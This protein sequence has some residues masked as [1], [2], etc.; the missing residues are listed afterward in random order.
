[1]ENIVFLMRFA[2]CYCAILFAAAAL[3]NGY[4]EDRLLDSAPRS[5]PT[6]R[7][8]RWTST[9][10]LPHNKV[11]C[12]LQ[13][14]DGYLWV[15]TEA[16]LARFDGVR[17]MVV[18]SG[19]ESQR[20]LP[21]VSALAED[22]DTNLWIASNAG[23][24]R[25]D[26]QTIVHY[27]PAHGLPHHK[28][29]KLVA[30]LNG[31][32]WMETDSNMARIQE[33]RIIHFSS[34]QGLAGM[35][36]R[37]VLETQDGT[38]WLGDGRWRQQFDQQSNH[39]MPLAWQGISNDTSV[40][41]LSI[42]RNG[43]LLV[44]TDAGLYRGMAGRWQHYHQASGLTD[45][46]IH[47]IM[48]DS[49]G[50]VWVATRDAGVY[51]LEGGR[52][53][54]VHLGLSEGEFIVDAMIEDREG[55]LWFAT[56][57]G[58]IRLQQ[59]SIRTYTTVDGLVDDYVHCVH[60][61]PDGAIWV[62][63]SRGISWSHGGT[64]AN[65]RRFAPRTEM[66]VRSI[67]ADR[68]TNIWVS[69]YGL[70]TFQNGTLDE[71]TTAL[72]LRSQHIQSLYEDRMGGIWIG[73]GAG[74]VHWRDHRARAFTTFDGLGGNGADV[75][76]EDH[77]GDVWIGNAFGLHRVSGGKLTRFTQSDGLV[78]D[79]VRA[80]HKDAEHSLWIGTANGL[81]R[82]TAGKFFSFG[83]Q[84]GMPE[85]FINQILEDQF[86]AFWI[87]GMAG[88][89]RVPRSSLNAVAEGRSTCARFV[90][91][92]EAD[93]MLTS[94]TTGGVQPAGCRTRD[95]HLWFATTKGV[96]EI[97]PI[98]VRIN[99]NQPPIVIEQFEADDRSIFGG[100][101]E[102][103]NPSVET[104]SRIALS[105]AS[106]SAGKFPLG[107]STRKINLSASRA[108]SIAIHFTANSFVDSE[109][110]RFKYRLHGYDKIWR[111]PYRGER[112]ARYTN[113][114]PGDY[115]FQVIGCNS[116]GY[117]N[118]TG[119]AITFSLA[120]RFTQ[121]A[122]FRFSV[123]FLGGTV[124]LGL[125]AWRLRWQRRA[126]HAEHLAAVEGQRARIARDL[127][128]D[129][130]ATLTGIALELEAVH[131]HGKAKEAQLG[132]LAAEARA[133][134]LDVREMA[135]T[136]NPRC[137]NLG[138]LST[139]LA[140]LAERFCL[141]ADLDCKLDI[142]S[143]ND[144]RAVAARSRH[145]L[146]IVTKEL[147]AN[148]AKHAEAKTVQLKL[149]VVSEELSLTVQDDGRGFDAARTQTGSGLMNLRERLEQAGGVFE[150]HSR[151]GAGCTAVARFP[152]HDVEP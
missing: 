56:R 79:N 11:K 31:E 115:Q 127:H 111:T 69:S 86:G 128:D 13:T 83:K 144:R 119:A 54:P 62:G 117:W 52:F 73:T 105:P 20:P 141:A 90:S 140:E 122:W 100:P 103:M 85:L 8:T 36:P 88:I 26:G 33:G 142:P 39:F 46:F 29:W 25:L 148:I 82:L 104:N 68:N 32:L 59:L 15:G 91:F 41:S 145:E 2:Q 76:L 87:S 80:L 38:L 149:A 67:L 95:G 47:R 130:G 48:E 44:G 1:M 60:E 64:F 14:R 99:T 12:L 27:T 35:R 84:H 66:S 112:I 63:S 143:A 134:A 136:T 75:F 42:A 45:I 151:N 16:G 55:N 50:R 53:Q 30:R 121:T 23:L 34:Q 18:G 107:K 113:L 129:L 124:S 94:Q 131:R 109:K 9:H 92:A 139:F 118:E 96:V 138:S 71:V 146:L 137:D 132:T 114:P 22:N 70:W 72:G 3:F 65:Y 74:V 49:N 133:L 108:H 120:P 89:H 43:E 97:D 135:W 37:W 40:T 150:V 101:L 61:G 57:E 10:G 98:A 19:E 21:A 125:M 102:V 58:L 17:F 147:L 4:G 6:F 81:A 123:L 7:I 110:V 24:F 51:F 28:I 106:T 5:S 93:G 77:S 126:L 152:L 116:H 78:H